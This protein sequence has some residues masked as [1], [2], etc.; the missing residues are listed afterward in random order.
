MST[1][2]AKPWL[3]TRLP[4]GATF[5]EHV[6]EYPVAREQP[7]LA[8][9][10]GLVLGTLIFL[11]L[12]G[13]VLALYYVASEGNGYNSIQFIIRSVNFGWLIQSFHSTGTTM[14]FAVVYL[15]LFRSILA[16]SY[17][18][19][20]ELVWF[21]ELTGFILLL[22]AGYFGYLLADGATS[23]WS[24]HD[25]ALAAARLNGFPGAIGDW[26]FGG[27]AGPGT[28]ARIA[29]FHVVLALMLFA[30]VT[31]RIVAKRT[32]R[33]A[34]LRNA[35]AAHPYYTS[36]YFVAFVVFAVI[37]AVLVFF[38]PHLGENPLNAVAAD[39]LV[40]PAVITPPWYLL[41]ISAIGGT[42]SGTLGGIIAVIAGLGV[43]FA[44][45]WLDRS[46]P[47]KSTGFLYKLLVFILALDVIGL[48][49]V[50]A[51][52]PSLIAAILTYVFIAW[53]F[54]HFLVL[55]PLTTA[56]ETK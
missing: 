34:P 51:A 21:L 12:S 36:Q 22:L 27:P 38:A 4:L 52:P 1:E 37:F 11:A 16:S 18:T 9:L 5:R 41:P 40:V 10:G 23:Y 19:P 50:A 33:V 3:E 31:A 30:A 32:I 6:I 17:K 42:I 54:L 35:V 55:T 7:Y 28:L 53:Y 49:I 8:T 56:T 2:Q 39:P 44:L 20:G 15:S 45:P 48:S 47:G 46:K 24:L 14:I 43:L 26:I 13:V 29:V 25:A